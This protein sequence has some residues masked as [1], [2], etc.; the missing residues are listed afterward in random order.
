MLERDMFQ[1]RIQE[2]KPI[3]LHEFLY[4]LMQGFDSVVTKSDVEIGG[5]DQ[6]F[7]LLAGRELQRLYGQQT[8]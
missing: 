1:K 8:K 6:R 5:T 3:H 7:N 4:P 2:G